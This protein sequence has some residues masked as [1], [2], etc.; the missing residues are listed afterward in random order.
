MKPF[1]IHLSPELAACVDVQPL[2]L[3]TRKVHTLLKEHQREKD[4]LLSQR[5]NLVLED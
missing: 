2:Y 4:L 3:K 1:A 5:L